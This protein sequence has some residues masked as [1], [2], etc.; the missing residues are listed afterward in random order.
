MA[1]GVLSQPRHAH[2]LRSWAVTTL[3]PEFINA[4]L[5]AM[6]ARFRGIFAQRLPTGFTTPLRIVLATTAALWVGAAHPQI[7]SVAPTRAGSELRFR[8]FFR[9][10]IG[11][12]GIELTDTL[13]KAHG[14]QVRLTGYMV[15]QEE[16]TPGRFMLTPRPVQMSEHAD[17]E[18]DDLPAATV[19]VYLDPSQQDW[20]IPHVRGLVEISGQLLVGRH[21]APDGRITWV[22][23][24]LAPDATRSIDAHELASLAQGTPHTH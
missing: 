7:S 9:N 11:P 10:P 16:P 8:D 5:G 4:A 24:Q 22:R 20:A 17:G 6:G 12:H 18:A 15:Q 14:T 3:I 23:L 13:Q 1:A 21:E 2:G 19:M